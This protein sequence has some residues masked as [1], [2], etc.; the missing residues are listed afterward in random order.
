MAEKEKK[1]G[2]G[3]GGGRGGEAPSDRAEEK[4]GGSKGVLE[5]PN[6]LFEIEISNPFFTGPQNIT[7]YDPAV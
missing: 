4:K 7:L 3:K 6:K 5:M 2:K 1:E